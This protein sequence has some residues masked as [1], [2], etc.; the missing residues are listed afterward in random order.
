MEDPNISSSAVVDKETTDA[1]GRYS[2]YSSNSKRKCPDNWKEKYFKS[3]VTTEEK[4]YDS[5]LSLSQLKAYNLL[6][7]NILLEKQ[8]SKTLSS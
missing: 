4:R 1:D 3:F 5:E 6:L 7:K 8:L 2:Q